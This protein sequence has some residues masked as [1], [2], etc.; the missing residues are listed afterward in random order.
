M[1][2]N[3]TPSF[4][5]EKLFWDQDILHV[6][7]ID[8]VGRGCF[9]GPVVVAGVIFHPER[10][11]PWFSQIHDSK[12]LSASL[13]ETLAPLIQEHCVHFSIAEIPISV[14][15]D[16]GIGKA[17]FLGMQQVVRSC[18]AELVS[19]SQKTTNEIPDQVRDDNNK[20]AVLV[21]AFT[22]P[23]IACSQKAIVKGD[24]KSISIAAAS[25]IAKVYRDNLMS[26]LAQ[27]YKHYG[28]EKNKGYGTKD[29]REAIGIHGLSDMH[30]TSFD[31]GKYT[32]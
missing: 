10:L 26:K 17:T 6:I 28:F 18:H 12:L 30:R 32:I 22:I 14:I 16:V 21:D 1:K 8:E 24:Q 19:A 25:I 23:D 4:R 11:F 20:L 31:L 9:A 29:H 7:G 5:E 27:Q 15:N 3:F 13:R 2:A